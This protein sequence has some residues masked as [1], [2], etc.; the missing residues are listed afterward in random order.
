VVGERAGEMLHSNAIKLESHG[1][2]TIMEIQGDIA[3]FSEPFLNGAHQNAND[4]GAGKILLKIGTDAY[5]KQQRNCGANPDPVP[6][7]S[8]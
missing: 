2:V 7:E 6:N 5:I 8:E 1:A 3:A 4:Q